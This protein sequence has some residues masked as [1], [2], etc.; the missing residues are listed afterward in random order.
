MCTGEV[1]PGR[2]EKKQNCLQNKPF[3]GRKSNMENLDC[4]QDTNLNIAMIG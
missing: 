3:M 4:K 2:I 1:M